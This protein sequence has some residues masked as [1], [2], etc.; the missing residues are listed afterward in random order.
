MSGSLTAEWG[1][2]TRLRE[3]HLTGNWITG[4]ARVASV[5]D[6]TVRVAFGIT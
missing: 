3:L 1:S 6:A 5:D 4:A 2:M